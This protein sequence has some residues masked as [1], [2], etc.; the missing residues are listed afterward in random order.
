MRG[1]PPVLDIKLTEQEKAVLEERARQRCAPHFEV[2]RAK[3][4]LMASEGRRNVEIAQT[5]GIGV[6]TITIWRGDFLE[7]R[8]DSLKERKRSGR[9]RAFPP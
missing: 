4:L 1:R 9:P 7:R 2:I 6:R 3:A 5:V 8:L